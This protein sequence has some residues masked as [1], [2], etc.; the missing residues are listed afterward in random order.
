M[1]SSSEKVEAVINSLVKKFT[2]PSGSNLKDIEGVD[3]SSVVELFL[4]LNQ[5]FPGDVGCLSV[6]FF[7]YIK[8]KPGEA[9]FLKVG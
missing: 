3:S 6:F 1:H 8:M 4:R 5:Q 9:I 2:H 7:N